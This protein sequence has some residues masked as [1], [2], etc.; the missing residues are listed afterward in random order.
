[1]VSTSGSDPL[2]AVEPPASVG[3]FATVAQMDLVTSCAFL[4]DGR[5]VV[6]ELDAGALVATLSVAGPAPPAPE[7]DRPEVDSPERLQPA[8]SE[9]DLSP[10]AAQLFVSG[11]E[12]AAGA[13]DQV[14]R[15]V[16]GSVRLVGE[17]PHCRGWI[18]DLAHGTAHLLDLDEVLVTLAAG[19][20]C[21]IEAGATRTG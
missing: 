8:L 7:V 4:A 15:D 13:I 14:P 12:R 9:H 5:T 16:V 2:P 17:S 10:V 20:A 19:V 3:P 21:W 6:F 1:M 18:V 11:T